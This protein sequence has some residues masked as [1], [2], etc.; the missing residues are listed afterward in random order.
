MTP[1]VNLTHL[2]FFCDAAANKSIS[3]A[4]KINYVSQ[5]AVSQAINKLESIFG[6]KL[7][8]HTHQKLQLTP[9]GK[10]LFEKA[11]NIFK[12]V[13]ETLDF[14]SQTKSEVMGTLKFITTRSLA[15]SL[16]APLYQKIRTTLPLLE[17]DFR[18]GGLNVIR[19][20]LKREEVEFAIVLYNENFNQFDK[21]PLKQ[22]KFQLYQSSK[23]KPDLIQEGIFVD[24]YEGPY[25]KELMEH[26]EPTLKVQATISGWELVA[27]FTE[28]NIGVGFLPDY[29]TSYQRFPTIEP[30]SLKI[31]KFEYELCAIHN[32]SSPLSRNAIAFLDQFC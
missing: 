32:K 18:M 25:V 10:I 3:E 21:Y 26:L 22:G 12:T 15:M 27:R 2:K 30:H 24:E 6:A 9:E 5:S 20:A 23:A 4:A 11:P 17:M 31:P 7:I 16:L 13:K 8:L 1:A 14:L 29:V 28:L 19:T